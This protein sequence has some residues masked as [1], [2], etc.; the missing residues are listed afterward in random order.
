MHAFLENLVAGVGMGGVYGLVAVGY[1]L[2]FCTMGLVNFAHPQV[3]LAGT[4][5]GIVVYSAGW[6]P[7]PAALVVAAVAGSIL[8]LLLER[9][10]RRLARVDLTYM[11]VATIGMGIVLEN[12][13]LR[14][15]GAEGRGITYGGS[16]PVAVGTVLVIPQYVAVI[17]L[18]AAIAG[19][20]MILLKRTRIG[21]ALRVVAYDVEMAAALGIP[22]NRMNALSL[23]IAS[24]L[25][26]AGGFLIA[27]LFYVDFVFGF[28][29]GIKGFVA[30]VIGTYGNIPGALLGG[31]ILGVL[32]NFS[33]AYLSSA[34][35]PTLIFV[36]MLLVLLVR[37]GGLF[38][39]R[40]RKI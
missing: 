33:T 40:F 36:F 2:V 4:F 13:L 16:K 26:A 10:F 12:L 25:A 3:L 30:A 23:A 24:A 5:I 39:T 11:L 22:V 17:V 38:G 18:T 37:P 6:L 9:V 19:V 1:S 21:L 7:Y 29:V 27:P 14:I 20:L 35:K 34:Y 8:G 31:L 28:S 15:F 32:E